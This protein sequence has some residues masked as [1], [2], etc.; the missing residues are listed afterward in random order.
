M[1]YNR[2]P[3]QSGGEPADSGG[4]SGDSNA[5]RTP[6]SGVGSDRALHDGAD[7]EALGAVSWLSYVLHLAVALAAVIP[8][9]QVSVVLLLLAFII[10][11]VKRKDAEGTWMESHFTFRISTVI[12]AGVLYLLSSPLWLLLVL[13]GVIAWGVVSLWFLYRIIKGMLALS[14]EQ[15]VQ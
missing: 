11:L 14:K 8:G 9:F 1:Q 6:A 10:D 5:Y 3:Q 15:T 12:W 2:I 4:Y 7:R 13:P